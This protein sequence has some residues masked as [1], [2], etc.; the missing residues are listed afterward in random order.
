MSQQVH[1]QLP[2]QLVEKLHQ[3]AEAKQRPFEAVAVAAMQQGV[4]VDE[5]L[6]ETPDDVL[7]SFTDDQLWA[8]VDQRLSKA[9]DRRYARL[10]NKGKEDRRSPEDE[11]EF[12][13]LLHKINFQMLE[14]SKA[15][16]QLQ[17]RGHD[18]KGGYLKTGKR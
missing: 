15:L 5:L 18:I 2:D 10:R 17:A 8:V 7:E 1:L 16:L 6:I 3:I 12:Q 11:A 13:V 9:E 14:R 4:Q